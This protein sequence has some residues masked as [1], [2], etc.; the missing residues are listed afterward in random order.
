MATSNFV[1]YR[2]SPIARGQQ[3]LP[4][5]LHSKILFEVIKS[6]IKKMSILVVKSCTILL[7]VCVQYK[8]LASAT[9]A[10]NYKFFFPTEAILQR[11]LQEFI[12]VI[13]GWIT[14]IHP[15]VR[16]ITSYPP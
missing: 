1:R 10:G 12:S 11:V 4:N 14:I 2:L 8:M 7:S 6:E 15:V 9:A 5:L 13:S 3:L 16:E